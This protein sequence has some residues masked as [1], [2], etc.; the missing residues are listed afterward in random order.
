MDAAFI[1][2][3]PADTSELTVLPLL[4]EPMVA[5]LPDTHPLAQ[6][7]RD[8]P[9]PLTSLADET[10]ILYG[11]AGTGMYDATIAACHTAGFAPRVGNLAATTQAAPRIASTLSLV[12]AGLGVCCVPSSLQRMTMDGVTYRALDG[13][14]Q[15]WALLSLAFRR[16]EPS[17]VVEQFVKVARATAA[18]LSA[19]C[20]EPQEHG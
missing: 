5:A 1:R 10:F 6:G 4:R 9:I 7:R 11:P 18:E 16:G 19:I 8:G 13:P 2:I 3:A 20:P 15:P 14:S 17:A 12:A